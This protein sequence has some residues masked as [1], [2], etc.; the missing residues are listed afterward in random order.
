MTTTRTT[1]STNQIAALLAGW[2]T[3]GRGGG[4]ERFFLLL[5]LERGAADLIA[6]PSA[7]H[8][9]AVGFRVVRVSLAL[10][11]EATHPHCAAGGHAALLQAT[12]KRTST[13]ALAT[14]QARAEWLCRPL[15]A[16]AA[17]ES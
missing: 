12:A 8:H 14:Q 17:R 4:A 3:D 16:R 11:L 6:G 9:F 10:G 1:N 5:K 7:G 15:A 13:S 2:S